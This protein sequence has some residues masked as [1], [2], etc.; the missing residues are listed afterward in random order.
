MKQ[1][2]II[3]AIIML[4][5]AACGHDSRL[6]RADALMYPQPDKA[7]AL[8]DSI[9]PATL[10]GEADRARYALLY[11]Q[12]QNKNH[13]FPT[14]DSLIDIAVDYYDRSGHDSLRMLAH[15]YRSAIRNSAAAY[16]A[17]LRDG[18]M[19]KDIAEQL[20]MPYWVARASQEIADA[21]Y[22]S[23]DMDNAIRYSDIAAR[24]FNRTGYHLN[25]QYVTVDKAISL[26]Y[27]GFHDKAIQI[28]D[29]L[30]G[31]IDS[32]DIDITT[33]VWTAYIRPLNALNRP[34]EA[35]AYA[36]KTIVL[37]PDMFY[38]P[39]IDYA[40]VAISCMQLEQND[41][42]ARYLKIA[43]ERKTPGY[44][45][46]KAWYLA[47]VGDYKGAYDS[48]RAYNISHSTLLNS[49]INNSINVEEK[50]YLVE[51]KESEIR[52][53]HLRHAINILILVIIILI[54]IYA[55]RSARHSRQN[56]EQRLHILS[57]TAKELTSHNHDLSNDLDIANKH[58]SENLEQKNI[59]DHITEKLFKKQFA[60]IS[61]LCENY[62][63]KSL[64]PD[65]TADL[66][67]HLEQQLQFIVSEGSIKNM[68]EIINHYSNGKLALLTENIKLKKDELTLLTLMLAGFSIRSICVLMKIEYRTYHTKRYR[69]KEKLQ[70]VDSPIVKGIADFLFKRQAK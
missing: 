68:Q 45:Y 11:S 54:S 44:P 47:K 6:D 12:A 67:R 56:I 51:K 35:L 21:Y 59:Y 22:Q 3:A 9:D 57:A 60:S 55:W 53:N 42:A 10:S 16:H 24:D 1:S 27:R 33:Y 69:L 36:Q 38:D 7:L 66:T 63:E 70:Q 4:V 58:L 37:E 8:L 64:K 2:A 23:Y 13:I 5:A 20:D 41:S 52:E 30:A 25:A 17:A 26:S 48:I 62:Y 46:A 29:S 18:L 65:A 19:A 50:D 34:K 31:I 43:A 32:T 15:F 28:L 49:F 40:D 61:E 14:S 39:L